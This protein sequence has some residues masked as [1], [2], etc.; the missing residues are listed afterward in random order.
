[1]TLKPNRVQVHVVG[2][3]TPA[4]KRRLR[5]RLRR[6]LRVL[7]TDTGLLLGCIAAIAAILYVTRAIIHR[8]F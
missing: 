5:L 3:G 1:M 4:P 8:S 7:A 6:A 2:D